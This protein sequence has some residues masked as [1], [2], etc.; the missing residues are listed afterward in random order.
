MTTKTLMR[1]NVGSAVLAGFILRLFLVL[2][3]PVGTSGDA[4]FYIG[5]A[6]NWLKNGVYGLEVNG[7]L[8]P[9]DIRV[10]GY[11]AF[12]ASI[13]T[14]AGNSPRAAMLAQVLVDLGTCFLIALIA[15]RLAPPSA[16]RRVA[17]AGLW[18]AALCP[19]IANYSAVVLSEVLVTFL[20][21][22]GLL[23][24]LQTDFA[25]PTNLPDS[26]RAFWNHSLSP[27]FLA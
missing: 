19:F 23:I 20:T 9:V 8:M 15:A 26:A 27:W 18:L 10:P 13:F 3:F 21:A 16:R 24:L 1:L 12:L 5:L 4:P 2:K 14:F 22:L 17:L 25:Q 11:P 6:W 7:Q